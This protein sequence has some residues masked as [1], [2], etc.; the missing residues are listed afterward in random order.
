VSCTL[1]VTLTCSPRLYVVRRSFATLATLPWWR[2]RTGRQ[3][4]ILFCSSVQPSALLQL[5]GNM[6][7]EALLEATREQIAAALTGTDDHTR[8]ETA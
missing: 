1:T 6:A 5:N 8:L 2:L 7:V 4:E 3:I